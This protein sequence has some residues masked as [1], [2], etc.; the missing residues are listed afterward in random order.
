MFGK[1]LGFI[2]LSKSISRL[3]LIIDWW[4]CSTLNYTWKI[5]RQYFNY[6]PNIN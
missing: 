2:N 1:F 4:R 6:L 3:S 5:A